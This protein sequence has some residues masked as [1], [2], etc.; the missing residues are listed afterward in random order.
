MDAL[1]EVISNDSQL[2]SGCYRR[3]W[4]LVNA[5]ENTYLEYVRE[6]AQ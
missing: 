4:T 2:P 1:T 6:L 5:T 3:A